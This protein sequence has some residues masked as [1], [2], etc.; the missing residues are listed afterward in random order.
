MFA[1]FLSSPVFFSVLALLPTLAIVLT[2]IL[3]L[4]FLET[5]TLSIAGCAAYI[6]GIVLMHGRA[7]RALTDKDERIKTLEADLEAERSA[8]DKDVSFAL[9]QKNAE[10]KFEVMKQEVE[11]KLI[12]ARA[13][14]DSLKGQITAVN[15]ALATERK[16]KADL[17]EE[18]V[19]L[20][21]TGK[22]KGEEDKGAAGL[23]SVV[24]GLEENLVERDELL[25]GHENLLRKILD[26]V[27]MIQRQLETVVN[28]TESSAIQIGDKVRYIYDKAQ[29]H[30][31]ESNEISNQFSG[32]QVRGLD[33]EE[34]LSL[35]AVL[36]GALQL[37]KEM[38]DMLEENG[39]LNMEYS[40]SASQ[41][42]E[43]TASINKITE[44]I[45]YISD[46]T[47]LLALN[48]AIEAARAG[49]HG[50]GFSV[51]AEEVR[52]L[53][54]RTNQA[55]NDITQI[56]GKVNDS[57]QE[58]S[59]SLTAN[60]EKTRNKKASVDSAVLSLLHTAKES[61]EVF[62]KLVQS[63][64]V[65]S[66][67]VAH[68]IDQIV[69]SLQFQDITR[70]EIQGAV[71]P[72][73]Q[74]GGLAQE[75]VTRTSLRHHGAARLTVT[76]G[77]AAKSSAPLASTPASAPATPASSAPVSADAKKPGMPFAPVAPV[78]PVASPA[79][80]VAA[81]ESED[82]KAAASGDVLMF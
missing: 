4:S 13:E 22:F 78:A 31:A 12:Q 62:S 46:Q 24:R 11:T 71:N 42:L 73:K 41:I 49:E 50:R 36:N 77:G 6:T 68:N 26:L 35:S 25:L 34:R 18:V 81:P 20:R 32:K 44:D 59:T 48:A 64:V 17:M 60:L 15:E 47:N 27:P 45:Q 1:S 28:H 29:E 56:V 19:Q 37:L 70:Q 82:T 58:I 38:T 2:P 80:A 79:P 33:G 74:I 21:A 30:L 3:D 14:V 39:R 51:V 8:G 9:V 65:S 52:K 54:D 66:E 10:R 40:K 5:A 75:M 69:M 7:E 57:V 61:T 76:N 55:S 63:S 16:A 53:S 23:L 67:S 72:L 43:N